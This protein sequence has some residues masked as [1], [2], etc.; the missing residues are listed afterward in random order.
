MPQLGRLAL[1][2]VLCLVP[3]TPTD[4]KKY[5]VSTHGKGRK[6]Q[7]L[8]LSDAT[9][10]TD[11]CTSGTASEAKMTHFSVNPR[12]NTEDERFRAGVCMSNMVLCGQLVLSTRSLK[13]W[14]ARDCGEARA[15]SG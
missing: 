11:C 2:C 13:D 6:N 3:A 1:Y 9:N 4:T 5:S 15:I 8:V 14:E 7:L 10:G 12:N